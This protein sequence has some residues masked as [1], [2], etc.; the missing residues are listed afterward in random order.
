MIG[1]R[2]RAERVRVGHGEGRIVVIVAQDCQKQVRAHARHVA[3]RCR[4]R[5]E[6]N[7]D[8]VNASKKMAIMSACL[9]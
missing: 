5:A 7:S 9:R 6:R 4:G 2:V 8:S 1:L 3:G